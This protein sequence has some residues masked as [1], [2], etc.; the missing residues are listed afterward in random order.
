[1]PPNSYSQARRI[2]GLLGLI[3]MKDQSMVDQEQMT[4]Y[5]PTNPVDIERYA[6][7]YEFLWASNGSEDSRA[8]E[9]YRSIAATTTLGSR[10]RD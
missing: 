9:N 2:N 5:K 3:G 8:M 7:L 4:K 1:M 6:S 10:T